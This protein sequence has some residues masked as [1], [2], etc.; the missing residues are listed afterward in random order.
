MDRDAPACLARVAVV[1]KALGIRAY[2]LIAI[3]RIPA[4]T[5][6][7]LD[8]RRCDLRLS[9][10][11]AQLSL[12]KLPHIVLFGLFFLITV[13]QFDRL[14]RRAFA[15]SLLATFALGT[16]VELEEGATRTGN[17]RLTDLLP[18]GV[19]ALMAMMLVVAT[20]AI[21][22]RRRHPAVATPRQLLSE[23]GQIFM[24]MQE[25]FF[26]RR[27]AMLRDRFGTSWMLL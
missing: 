17:C 1:A 21:R 12:T 7:P 19:G 23:G 13:V 4:R 5:G 9:L 26:A 6:F 25:T 27:F 14:D 8:G 16:L 24:P 22:D 18:D 2:M 15:W 10:E 3:A 20:L 11:N